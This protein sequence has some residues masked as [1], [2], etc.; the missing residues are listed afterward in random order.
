MTWPYSG[1]TE[2]NRKDEF[3]FIWRSSCLA[4]AFYLDSRHMRFPLVDY[5]L[6]RDASPEKP[7]PENWSVVCWHL[8]QK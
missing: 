7:Q 2:A 8:G 5:W 3:D 4:F 6:F 1:R